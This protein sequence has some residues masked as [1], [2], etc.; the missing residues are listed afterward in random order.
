MRDAAHKMSWLLIAV[1]YITLTPLALSATSPADGNP[2]NGPLI[3]AL[4]DSIT[5]GVRKDGSVLP[6]QTFANR[7][8]RLLQPDFFGLRMVNAGIPLNNTRDVLQRLDRDVL[9]QK[10]DLVILMIGTN[11]AAYVDGA[12]QGKGAIARSQPRVPPEEFRKNL[13]D[14]LNR[15]KTTGAVT[16]L[17]T[18]IPMSRSYPY[19]NVGYYRDH[20]INEAV[21]EYADIV[22]S[23]ASSTHTEI[24]DVFHEWISEKNYARYLVDGVHPN[25]E[26][27]AKIASALIDRCRN[28][29]DRRRVH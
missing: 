21:R 22:I 15:V 9:Q 17:V 6:E 11:D 28:V 5:Y 26:G 4:G 24:V 19:S 25:P 18:P 7:L 16:I 13:I 2:H 23:V 10:P 27:H 8:D 3:I 29:L 14:I 12:P 20:D 1:S